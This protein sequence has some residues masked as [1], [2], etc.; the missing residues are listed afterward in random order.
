M[1]PL[2]R[3]LLVEELGRAEDN[4]H[5]AKHQAKRCDPNEPYGESGTTL[6]A[7]I[8]GYQRAYDAAKAELE[9]GL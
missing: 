4:L 2:V 8:A 6:A 9:S 5:R 3:R 1:S 7:I